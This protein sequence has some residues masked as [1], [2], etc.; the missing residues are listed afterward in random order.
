M[1]SGIAQV[2][3][4]AGHRVI[5]RDLDEELLT[6]AREGVVSGRFGLQSG[7]ERGIL[8]ADAAE[9]ALERLRFTTDA[10]EAV[11]DA[12]VVIEAVPERLDLK[13]R[14]WR[15]L[16]SCAP[17]TA[18]FASNSSGFSVSAMGAAL[19]H[20]ER[21]VGWHWAS[22]AQVMRMAEIVKG[23]ATSDATV[24][25]VVRLASS[26]GKNPIVVGDSE[27]EWGY[28]ANRVYGAMIREAKQV[29]AEGIADAEQV[30]QLMIDC[31]RWPAGPFGMVRGAGTGWT[32]TEK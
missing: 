21:L 5:C 10:E 6:S 24:D 19:D 12:D 25:T 26:V 28:V 23:R 9:A 22:P 17:T 11:S 7:V 30:D 31:F 27:R 20:P 15:E 16:E 3:A 32:S 14:L 13:I 8:D 4:V 1:G 29:I 2:M 18:I